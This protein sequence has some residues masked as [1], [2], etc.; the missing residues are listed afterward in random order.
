[1]AFEPRPGG[2]TYALDAPQS[3]QAPSLAI[4]ANPAT[5]PHSPTERFPCGIEELIPT[6]AGAGTAH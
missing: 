4:T 1:M 2:Q 6:A 5:L 3:R